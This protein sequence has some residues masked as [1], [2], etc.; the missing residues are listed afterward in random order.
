MVG[1]FHGGSL[2][3]ILLGLLVVLL[4]FVMLLLLAFLCLLLMMGLF[5]IDIFVE[6]E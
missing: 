5:Q 6:L 3:I 1:A 2:R 4:L